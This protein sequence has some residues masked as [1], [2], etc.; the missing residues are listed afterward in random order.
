MALFNQLQYNQHVP[1]YVGAPLDEF[2]NASSAVQQRY[3]KNAEGYS[4]IGELADSLQTS[5]LA[6]DK[7]AKAEIL[8]HVNRSIEEAAKKGNFDMMGNEMRMLAKQYSKKATPIK[9]NLARYQ[10]AQKEILDSKLPQN[11]QNYLLSRLNSNP[12]LSFDEDGNPQYLQADPFAENVNLPEI[13]EKYINDYKSDKAPEGIHQVKDPNTGLVEYYSNNTNERVDSNEVRSGLQRLAFY[14]PKVQQ[15]V[16]QDAAANGVEL[17]DANDFVEYA[18][19]LMEAYVDKAAFNKKDIDFKLGSA[20]E[21]RKKQLEDREGEGYTFNINWGVPARQGVASP[22]DLR[23]S[24]TSLT[25]Q[26]QSIND[27]FG[28][29]LKNNGDS[30]DPNTGKSKSGIDYSDEVALYNQKLDTI[31]SQKW[32]LQ[33]VE[34]QA[35]IDAGLSANYIPNEKVINE[36]QK[37][38]DAQLLDNTDSNGRFRDPRPIERRYE[39]ATKAYN[40]VLDSSNDPDLKAYRSA[41]AK[42]AKDRT[43]V[44]GITTFGKAARSEMDLIGNRLIAGDWGFIKGTDVATGRELENLAEYGTATQ[45]IGW[46]TNNGEIELVYQT[47]NTDKGNFIPGTKKIKVTAPP[48]L[49]SHLVEKGLINPI[50][51]EISRQIGSTG[52][53]VKIGNIT[54]DVEIKRASQTSPSEVVV[55][56]DTTQGK[57]R[58][59][60]PSQGAAIKVLSQLANRNNGN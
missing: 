56:F 3:D 52:G 58:K 50:D 13:Y 6:G 22:S 25:S 21:Y 53:R 12:G 26:K 51:L 23:K 39:D 44:K 4:L 16:L 2:Y 1:Q 19:P 5:N 10:S 38:Y 17:R 34:A 49:R 33:E 24:T 30:I 36:A 60:Y 20:E 54:A 32:E 55:I 57:V 8:D 59:A 40:D 11:H 42:N 35:K 27:E 46:T 9:E 28:K 15:F 48:E 18:S 43:D 14:D 29:F 45:N 47:G 41:L 31:D 7:A 37:A